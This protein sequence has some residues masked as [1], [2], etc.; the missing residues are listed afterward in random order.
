MDFLSPL[1]ADY[2]LCPSLFINDIVTYSVKAPMGTKG[3]SGKSYCWCMESEDKALVCFFSEPN[4]VRLPDA[5]NSPPGRHFSIPAYSGTSIRGLSLGDDEQPVTAT[6][7]IVSSS[8][9]HPTILCLHCMPQ[10]ERDEVSLF[11]LPCGLHSCPVAW[12]E[13]ESGIPSE[14]PDR[15]KLLNLRQLHHFCPWCC[16]QFPLYWFSVPAILKGWMDRVLC[17][18]F[19]FDIPGFYDSGFLKVC[20]LR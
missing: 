13:K 15:L 19:A 10:S 2:C 12:E 17:Q 6:R 9:P 3:T 7:T 11:M 1:V 8:L 4:S 20:A 5:S 14:S 16:L 18:G